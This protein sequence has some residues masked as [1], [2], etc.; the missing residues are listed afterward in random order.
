MMVSL[1]SPASQCGQP[2]AGN[3]VAQG[4]SALEQGK[5]DVAV[6][7]LS[8]AI[9]LEPENAEALSRRGEAY[10]QK[11]DFDRALADCNQAIKL[12]P[13]SAKG[14]LRRGYVYFHAND[15]ER[16][17]AD[18]D[19][20]IRLDP[21]SAPVYAYRGKAY[22]ELGQVDRAISDY[23]QSLRLDPSQSVLYCLRGNAWFAK[24]NYD[25][26]WDDYNKAIQVDPASA[27]AYTSRG[28]AAAQLFA[29]DDAI[30][31]YN[32]AIR[33]DPAYKAVYKY[34]DQAEQGKRSI[35]WGKVYAGLFGVGILALVFAAFRAYRSPTAFS[36]TVDRRFERTTD[37]NLTFYPGR[38]RNGYLVPDTRTEQALRSFVRHGQAVGLVTGF[39]AMILGS[40][41]LVLTFPMWTWLQTRMGIPESAAIWV[42][43]YATFAV[44]GAALFSTFALWRRS[45]IRGL[46][47][48]EGNKE[49]R[50]RNQWF[51]DFVEDMP[52]AVRWLALG[53]IVFMFYVSVAGLSRL[54]NELAHVGI[55]GLS[56]FSLMFAGA[57]LGGLY[58]SGWFLF[59][60]I[61][62]WRPITSR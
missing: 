59:L 56:F 41:L 24:R 39:I 1:P 35:W 27:Q 40:A 16:A 49:P 61:G 50:P 52:V 19:T 48:V 23:D 33:A 8:A 36:H 11:G 62:L 10:A 18:F 47:E 54:G 42:F 25:R 6:E 21:R 46:V 30:A 31:D 44:V 58:L 20:T 38:R 14:Y 34:R 26:A 43:S 22:S 45:A 53:V 57:D 28:F 29:Y 32:E 37:G 15:L 51:G 13:D 12:A 2:H 55:G 3:L 5:Y 4:I 9:V 17:I 7:Q 60:A